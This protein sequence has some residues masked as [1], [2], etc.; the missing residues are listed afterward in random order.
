LGFRTEIDNNTQRVVLKVERKQ[1][2]QKKGKRALGLS[3][4]PRLNGEF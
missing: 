3:G 1:G 4:G 2:S